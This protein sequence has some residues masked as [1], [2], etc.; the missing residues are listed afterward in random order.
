VKKE[1]YFTPFILFDVCRF[2]FSDVFSH[3]YRN[4]GAPFSSE[5]DA[6]IF[7]SQ[8]MLRYISF[9]QV[10]FLRFRRFR[11]GEASASIRRRLFRYH[12]MIAA[13]FFFFFSPFF[14]TPAA[15]AARFLRAIAL[16]LQS[17][18]ATPPPSLPLLFRLFALQAAPAFLLSSPFLRL[19]QAVRQ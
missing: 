10:R 6:I 15:A 5:Y 19:Q 12:F 4:N 9:T 11:A 17:G 3:I 16:S 13:S 18:S 8:M 7:V 2:I 14:F 1:S